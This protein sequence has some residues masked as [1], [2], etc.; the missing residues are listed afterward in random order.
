VID[1]KTI[2]EAIEK[3]LAILR[4]SRHQS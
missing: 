1:G 4:Q 3:G 2:G